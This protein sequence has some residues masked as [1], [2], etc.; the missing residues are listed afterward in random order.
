MYPSHQ[1]TFHTHLCPPA[2]FR[3]HTSPTRFSCFS[4][5]HHPPLNATSLFAPLP[6]TT[7]HPHSHTNYQ[8][9]Y[10]ARLARPVAPC[11]TRSS[12]LAQLLYLPSLSFSWLAAGSNNFQSTLKT[13]LAPCYWLLLIYLQRPP[14]NLAI[15]SNALV[16][17]F[18]NLA[19]PRQTTGPRFL[20]PSPSTP[21]RSLLPFDPPTTTTT[22]SP[23]AKPRSILPYI[24]VAWF[25][26]VFLPTRS[27]RRAREVMVET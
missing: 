14:D 12:V 4:T 13:T 6:P 9:Q 1:V 7:T 19:R 16:L 3:T 8:L 21:S 24:R 27:K 25:S 18:S 23:L 15:A 5:T 11:T 17:L 20:Q 10:I 2:L 26:R 22:T